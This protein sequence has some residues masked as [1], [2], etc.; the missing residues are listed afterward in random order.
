[1]SNL[2][3]KVIENNMK[4]FLALLFL[5]II[6]QLPSV[7]AQIAFDLI[8]S[9]E[10]WGEVLNKSEIQDKPVFVDIY[11]DWCGYC[12]KMDKDVFSNDIVISYMND[13]YLNVKVDGESDFGKSFA[14]V[15]QVEGFPTY[16]FIDSQN[17]ALGYLEGYIELEEFKS[18]TEDVIANFQL[19]KIYDKRYLANSLST[20]ELIKYYAISVDQQ[21]K[22][23]IYDQLFK[24]MGNNPNPSKEFIHFLAK[25]DIYINDEA[26]AFMKK[27]KELIRKDH[28]DE[29]LEGIV[30]G[31]YENSLTRAILK[32][33]QKILDEILHD[34]IPYF[35]AE[36]TQDIARY[37]SKKIYHAYTN[38]WNKYENIV[39]ARSEEIPG[40]EQG[41]FFYNEGLSIVNDYRQFEE[42]LIMADVWLMKSTNIET[43][44]DSILLTAYVK[45]LLNQLEEASSYLAKA[46]ALA[47]GE[48][49][50]KLVSEIR[51]LVESA[52]N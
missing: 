34:L 50:E 15:H 42:A 27:H 43:D 24:E 11:T 9:E 52:D 22:K 5:V 28:G 7:N 10:D 29:E 13:N 40:D 36:E 19:I 37:D 31:I 14:E 1:M 30:N 16:V 45:A 41:V 6:Y 23:M 17:D 25:T 8:G 35:L 49:E 20:E 44:F 18:S 2:Q 21:K 26:Y 39:I 47:S 48:E 32:K 4:K 3:A 12:R 33:D 51:S 46:S 38:Q